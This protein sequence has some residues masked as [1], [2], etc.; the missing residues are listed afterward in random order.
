MRSPTDLDVD[1]Q[2][3]QRRAHYVYDLRVAA[4]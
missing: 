2:F 1:G 4:Y 3:R